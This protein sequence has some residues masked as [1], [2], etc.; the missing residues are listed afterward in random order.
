[1]HAAGCRRSSWEGLDGLGG[2]KDPAGGGAG[3]GAVEA[4][5]SEERHGVAI[6]KAPAEANLGQIAARQ[7]EAR[8][9]PSLTV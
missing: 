9:V 7:R 1:M 4:G 3:G 6:E 8:R 2:D 5:R